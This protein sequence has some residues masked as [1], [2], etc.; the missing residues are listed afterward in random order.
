[1]DVLVD[2]IDPG[3]RN[4]VML[5]TG[6]FVGLRKLHLVGAFHVVDGADVHPVR[7]HDFHVLMD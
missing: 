5:V 2:V 3:E 1:M 6:I 4:E 7:T